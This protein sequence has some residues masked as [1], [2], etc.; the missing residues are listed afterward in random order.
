MFTALFHRFSLPLLAKDLVEA[1]NRRR[2]YTLRVVYA[3][4]LYGLSLMV[5]LES[6]NAL[7]RSA[8]EILG[9][10]GELLMAAFMIQCFGIMLFMPAISVGAISI[11]KE[12]NTLTLLFLTRLGP[13]TILF[14]KYLAR[15]V[16][17]AGFLLI[18]LPLFGIAYSLGG[19]TQLEIWAAIWTLLLFV[20]QVGAVCLACSAFF[21]SSAA[22]FIWSYLINI[23]L[24]FLPI[25]FAE[26]FTSYSTVDA[27][28]TSLADSINQVAL[29]VYQAIEGVL[30]SIGSWL[31][32]EDAKLVPMSSFHRIDLGSDD[33]QMLFMPVNVYGSTFFGGVGKSGAAAWHILIRSMPIFL[34][35]VVNLCLARRWLVTRAAV[36]GTSRV[37][38]L[39]RSI[40]QF[41]HRINQN[42]WMKGRV[43]WKDADPLPVDHPIAWRE[44]TKKALGTF[45]YLVRILVVIE[46][47]L[48]TFCLFVLAAGSYSWSSRSDEMAL[49]SICV[50]VLTLLSVISKASATIPSERLRE[51]FDVLLATPLSTREIVR[52]KFAGVNRLIWV[53]SIPLAT[54]VACHALW[55]EAAARP[56][57]SNLGLGWYLL[58]SFAAIRIYP[59]MVAWLSILIALIVKTQSRAIFTTLAVVL[60]WCVIPIVGVIFIEIYLGAGATNSP[61][62]NF[63]VIQ[64]PA[65]LIGAIETGEFHFTGFIVVASIIEYSLF[66]LLFRKLAM[67]YSARLLGRP[68]T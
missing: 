57:W 54:V 20:A 46:I 53:L 56:L 64:S 29:P 59:R 3:L 17:M 13:W 6:T 23:A 63:L 66:T 65:M 2:T 18:S 12:K 33:L 4:L 47:P 1:A 35:I 39:F 48:A 10:G 51:T 28:A 32:Y 24:Y 22:A 9:T 7:R 14:E 55:I 44:T 27:I 50:W 16:Q 26:L 61:L 31:G 25:V 11:E 38:W 40:D 37:L 41:F 49:A 8:V 30:R 19:V 36:T 68:E 52:Q 62:A 5:Y 15:C 34:V 45:R 58:G 67:S 43:V 60:T 42:S 21:Q